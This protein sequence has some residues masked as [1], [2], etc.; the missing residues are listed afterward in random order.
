MPVNQK[1]PI[2]ELIKAVKVYTKNSRK[3]VTIEYVLLHGINDTKKD[4]DRLLKLLRGIP[5][6]VNLIAFNPTHVQ[7]TRPSDEHVQAF[8]EAIR[9]LSAP[10][11]LRLSKGDDINGA[12]GQLATR[13]Q[14]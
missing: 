12:C 6:K 14:T 2:Q 13:K 7:Y 9:P 4:A 10:V 3:R 5:C 1:Y 11:T 8:A